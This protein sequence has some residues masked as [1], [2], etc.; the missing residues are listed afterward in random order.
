MTKPRLFINGYGVADVAYDP[1]DSVSV[2]A[3]G[4]KTWSSLMDELYALIDVSKLTRNSTLSLIYNS[5][6][7]MYYV[8]FYSDTQLS[9]A[10]MNLTLNTNV[11]DI[12]YFFLRASNSKRL[13]NTGGSGQDLSGQTAP[14]GAIL[15]LYY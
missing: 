15:A 13:N 14:S 5:V 6:Y 4:V 11:Y 1:V 2:T 7:R 9:A 10:S 12:D 8:N 3:D